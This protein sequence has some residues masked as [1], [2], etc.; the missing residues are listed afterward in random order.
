MLDEQ[1]VLDKL[2]IPDFRHL[3]K[4]NVMDL[5][6]ELHE[7]D[8]EVA[9]KILEQFPE[10]AKVMT[11]VLVDYRQQLDQ[12][13]ESDNKGDKEFIDTSNHEIEMLESLLSDD[14]SFDQKMEIF[15]RVDGIREGIKE[16]LSEKRHFMMG[17]AKVGL[18]AIGT[19]ITAVTTIVGVTASKKRISNK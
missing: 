4:D 1:A 3:T 11:E 15:D 9:M 13:L 16:H 12:I 14:L 6:T 5:V 8:P 18:V 2:K 19:V 10:F 17:L 7:I